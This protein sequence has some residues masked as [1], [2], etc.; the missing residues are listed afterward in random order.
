[1]SRS[2]TRRF[3]PNPLQAPATMINPTSLDFLSAVLAS[4]TGNA[5]LRTPLNDDPIAAGDR[6]TIAEALEAGAAESAL[7]THTGELLG[8]RLIFESEDEAKGALDR[9]GPPSLILRKADTPPVSV[10]LLNEP[11][12]H[13]DPR[14]AA[15]LSITDGGPQDIPI[16]GVG[17]WG[18]GRDQDAA[19]VRAGTLLDFSFGDL[20][21]KFQSARP[22]APKAAPGVA[23]E[24]TP[25]AALPMLNDAVL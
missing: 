9:Y 25:G 13:G 11:I 1:M 8:L 7:K 12:D 14:A 6:E 22:A 23:P 3:P 15:F 5:L 2:R 16:V 19:N 4:A 21:E 20:V 17:G 18:Y 24:A 10:F